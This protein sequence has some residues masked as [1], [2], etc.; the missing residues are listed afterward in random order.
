MMWNNMMDGFGGIGLFW[1]PIFMIG[2]PLL[3]LYLVFSLFRS[4]AGGNDTRHDFPAPSALDVLKM[5]YARG[6]ID[7]REYEER[8]RTL[9]K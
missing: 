5:R 9:L 1:G 2:I 7:E 6:E 4:A 8:K 3:I